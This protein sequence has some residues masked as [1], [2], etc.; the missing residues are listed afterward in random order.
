MSRKTFALLLVIPL[1]C[2]IVAR[3]IVAE[4]AGANDSADATATSDAPAAGSGM[5]ISEA[6]DEMFA[7]INLVMEKTLFFQV[8][9]QTVDV[10]VSEEHPTGKK[11][12]GIPFI[13]VVLALG[14]IFFTVRYGF[15]N[16]RLFGHAIQVVRGKFDKPDHHGE[17]S[18]FQALTSALS[19]TVGLGNIAGVAAAIALGGP[20]AIFWMWLI[21]FFGMSMKFSSCSFAQL[22]R[23]IDPDGRTLGGP[24]VYLQEGLAPILTFPVAKAFGVVYAVLCILASFGGGN[25]F[26][27]NQTAAALIHTFKFE[28]SDVAN[29]VIGFALAILAGVVIIG[30]IRRIGEVTSKIVPAMCLVYVGV[31]LFTIMTHI[32]QAGPLL[33]SIFTEAFTGNALGGGAAGGIIVVFATGA[34]RAVFSNEAGV[35]SAAIAHSAAKTDE[36]IR[37]GVVAMIGPFIDTIV[38][39][40]MTAL[41][42]LIT[43]V[44]GGQYS[45]KI[46]FGDGAIKT[47]EAFGTV[48]WSLKYVLCG[49]IFVFAYSTIISWSYYG[50]RAVEYLFGSRGVWPYRIIFVVLVFLGPFFSLGNVLNFSDFSLLSMA[51][52]NILGMV[53]L[54]GAVAAK[55]RDYVQRLRAGE[56]DVK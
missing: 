43:D 46:G 50:D 16:I 52:P 21:A 38:I 7:G 44:F 33:A 25:L 15:V 2:L 20:G 39:C 29:G 56:M 41:T 51:F 27:G 32:D 1:L 34:Q 5:R 22:Y 19:A 55:T 54:S 18:H 3:P 30:G 42:L 6:V 45:A 37:E 4:E 13:V 8:P 23:R 48:H 14:G 24:M 10:E 28:Q 31:C 47:I 26:Q 9:L 35:G 12:V 49:A 36:P 53:L 40:T 11:Q 17:I